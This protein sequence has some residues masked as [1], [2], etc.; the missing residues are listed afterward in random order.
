LRSTKV[1]VSVAA[2][3]GLVLCASPLTGVH[4]VESALALG[5]ALPPF[6]ALVAA[7]L[8]IS[9]RGTARTA[10][11]LARQ[12]M[13]VSLFVL[14][15]PVLVIALNQLLRVRN[16]APLEGLAFIA[17][18]PGI[19]CVLAALAGFAAA[20]FVRR[21]RLAG[22]IAFMVPV[23]ALGLG[24]Y[25]FWS[26]PA[27]FVFGHFGGWF[28][29]TIYDEGVT[30]PSRYLT[31]RAYSITWALFVY[32]ILHATFDTRS[33]L[34]NPR[35]LLRHPTHAIAIV[36]L[37]CTLVAFETHGPELGHRMTS[38]HVARHLGL[39]AWGRRCAVHVPRELDR[40]ELRRFVDDCDFRVELAERRMAVHEP[41]RVHA[42]FFRNAD[43]K[44]W[45]MGA[46]QTYIAKPWRS[47]VFLQLQ[48]WPHPVLAHEIVHVV[49]ANTASG[50]F[51]VGGQLGGFLPDPALIEG[52][53]VAIAWDGRSGLTPHQWSKAMVELDL[54]PPLDH[55]LGLGFLGQPARNAYT[56]AGS[57]IRYLLDT[58]GP[59]AV[60]EAYRTGGLE[61]ATGK[62]PA[63][64]EREWRAFLDE[65][66][67]PPQA[68]A[69][70]QMRFTQPGIFSAVCPH[71]VARLEMQLGEDLAAGDT[72]RAVASCEDILAID[73]ESVGTQAQLAG[74][75]AWLGRTADAER[76][77]TALIEKPAPTPIIARAR[78]LLADAAWR[79]RDYERARSIYHSLL[80]S[81]QEEEL[82]RTMEVKALA[83]DSEP[84][85]RRAIFDLLVGHDGRGSAPQVAVHLARELSELRPDGLGDY[86][87]A[88]QL[89]F[90]LDFERALAAAREARRR[91]LPTARTAAEA[92]RMEGVLLVGTRR[93][94]DAERL[95]RDVQN[96]RAA[97]VV[98][99][100]LAIEW[101][102]RIA[103]LRDRAG[104]AQAE[105]ASRNSP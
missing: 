29:G 73:P 7:R 75:L 55:V 17:V 35:R 4:G 105:S 82:L 26:S 62:S 104:R 69:L 44:Q 53:A 49:A 83:L 23:I 37:G 50:P 77:I 91:G 33:G 89:M 21:P 2:A 14:A 96:D 84:R 56:I 101:L 102:D 97:S 99:R 28:P 100:E 71:E 54:M 42:Y 41:R 3:L 80:D 64:L 9:E 93:Y 11:Q 6:C 67:L 52:V 61:I 86:L 8:A 60:S 66:E 88:R 1:A 92:R 70:A 45:F 90:A 20:A 22:T 47:E 27:I 48:A 94:E 13:G 30:L 34:A 40:R 103:W 57:F 81:P 5:A 98:D 38:E 85:D 12:V 63:E 95:Y 39:T 32:A 36:A 76:E 65:V 74:S 68:L 46:S 87:E 18:G 72:P 24:V 16:C 79:E 78:E 58:Y 43:E 31:F 19:G 25:E 59:R 15:V 51:K 10:A